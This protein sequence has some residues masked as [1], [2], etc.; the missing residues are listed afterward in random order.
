MSKLENLSNLSKEANALFF[1]SFEKFHYKRD[2][3]ILNVNEVCNYFY[4]LNKG[5]IRIFYMKDDKEITEWISLENHFFV[6]IISFFERSKSQLIIKSIEEV[7]IYGIS[8]DNLMMLSAENKEINQF[9][10]YSLIQSLILSQKRMYSIQFHT[11]QEKYQNLIENQAEI[12]KRIP[13]TYIAS[14]L[15]ITLETLSRIRAKVG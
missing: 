5:S 11:A 2:S 13:L 6:S 7:E 1:N 3:F 9:Y 10:H 12:I 14:F 15:G 4:Y 8:H